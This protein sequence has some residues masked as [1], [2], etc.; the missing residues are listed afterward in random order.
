MSKRD[1]YKILGVTK[2][3]KSS[4]I[5]KNYRERAKIFHPDANNGSK[6]E[7][8]EIKDAVKELEKLNVG[9]ILLHDISRDGSG[10]GYNIEILKLVKSITNRKIITLIFYLYNLVWFFS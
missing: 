10:E 6:K 1:Y 2:G 8:I 5:K 9:E 7:D 3:A 4:E